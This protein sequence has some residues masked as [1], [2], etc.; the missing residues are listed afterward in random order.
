MFPSL[1]DELGALLRSLP[2]SE[3]ALLRTLHDQFPPGALAF[4]GNSLPIRELNLVVPCPSPA[5][6]FA[7]RGANGIDG[8]VSTFLGLS[9]DAGP[10]AFLILG[11][12]SALYDL[13]A[14]WVL[15]QLKE[16]RRFIVVVNNGGGKIFSRVAS[17]RS[18]P[19]SARTVIENRHQIDF[20]PWADLWGMSHQTVAEPQQFAAL[21]KL[22]AGT[23]LVELRPDADQTEAF[24]QAWQA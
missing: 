7:N 4:V 12:L 23:H 10:D 3:P 2:L 5:T 16:R 6:F 13:A 11:D 22:P 1:E 18:L 21:G 20:K 8:L 14:P 24:W 17:L 9:A 19:E 15:P